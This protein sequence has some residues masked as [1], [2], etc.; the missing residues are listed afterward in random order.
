M[1]TVTYFTEHPDS[2]DPLID[3]VELDIGGHV[4]IPE[5]DPADRPDEP[6]EVDV[7]ETDD[8]NG[9]LT[10]HRRSGNNQNTYE[11][12]FRVS[13]HTATLTT[14]TRLDD[15]KDCTLGWV[16]DD[17]REAIKHHHPNMTIEI[18]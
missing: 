3:S 5:V 18:P 17:V 16:P 13:G 12:C 1:S 7:L 10:V 2:G 6:G 15:A 4:H 8:P 9:Y 14:L 11:F